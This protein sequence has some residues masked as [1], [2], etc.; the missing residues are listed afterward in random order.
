MAEN[1]IQIEALSD[2]ETARLAK[3][4]DVFEKY[5]Q[6]YVRVRP[7]DCILPASYD[8]FKDKIK[9]FKTRPG[10]VF[11][12]CFPKSG[13]TWTQELVTMLLYDCDFEKM[14]NTPLLERGMIFVEFPAMLDILK[15]ELPLGETLE[16]WEK[17]ELPRSVVSHLRHCLLP[18]GYLEKSKVVICIRNPKDTLVSYY[19][20]EKLLKMNGYV[21][22]FPTY[23]DLFM[24]G[25]TV[26]GPY[27]EY[28]KEAWSL[29]DHPNVCLLRFEEM[30]KDL[31]GCI[32]KVA[33][34][35]GKDLSE[36]LVKKSAEF[37]DF[38][39]MKSR[40]S[41]L[42]LL[43]KLKKETSVGDVKR[44]G[45]VGDWR[46]YFTEEM[47]KRMEE[48]IDKHFKPIGLHFEYE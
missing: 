34:F 12:L 15:A 28:I 3:V 17:I 42:N 2:E 24:D 47:N 22:D 10:D 32:R 19:H 18:N 45:A 6:R 46:N 21:G 11:V 13:T 25:L 40:P 23:F 20:H 37:L 9:N 36:E 39:S 27:F 48:A 8:K 14:T 4:Y 1:V 30:K 16:K 7:G 33:R 35:I 26:Y 38:K 43:D 41:T 5:G 44:K 29:R 31:P